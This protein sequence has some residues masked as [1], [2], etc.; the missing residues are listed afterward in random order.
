MYSYPHWPANGLYT[1]YQHTVAPV[2]GEAEE[3]R[4]KS[5]SASAVASRCITRFIL[6]IQ[7]FRGYHKV[8][9]YFL[10]KIKKREY[11]DGIKSKETRPGW[12]EAHNVYKTCVGT[13]E[14]F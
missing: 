5:T 10:Y 4:T 7:K 12:G 6:K 1:Q 13:T 11:R 8:R 3:E 2:F 14:G 9:E